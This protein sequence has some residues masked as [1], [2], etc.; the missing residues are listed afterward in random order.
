MFKDYE[1][2]R[3]IVTSI[4]AVVEAAVANK[5]SFDK[6][7]LKTAVEFQQSIGNST[8]NSFD[9]FADAFKDACEY[10]ESA[11]CTLSFEL[12]YST[13]DENDFTSIKSF[14]NA[15]IFEVHNK[16]DDCDAINGLSGE[17]IK[18]VF[19]NCETYHATIVSLLKQAVRISEN[20]ADF[21]SPFDK[22]YIENIITALKYMEKLN[23]NNIQQSCK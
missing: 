19:A 23:S 1:V 11:D 5:K 9:I 6:E 21:A 12:K 10:A 13:L 8:V 14:I 3:N 7:F 16:Y 22:R 15:Y 17:G 4:M 20:T 2:F 18:K